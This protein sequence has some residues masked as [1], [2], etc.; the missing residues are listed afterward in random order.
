M[1]ACMQAHGLVVTRTWCDMSRRPPR[2]AADGRL[3]RVVE[4]A[5][6]PKVRKLGGDA[7]GASAVRLQQNVLDL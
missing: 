4:N 2:G 6:Q 5:R 3:L 7:H 1:G